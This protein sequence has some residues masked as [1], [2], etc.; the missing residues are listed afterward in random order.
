MRQDYNDFLHNLRSG[1]ALA[2]MRRVTVHDFRNTF[3]QLVWLVLFSLLLQLGSGFIIAFPNPD[4]SHYAF[5]TF[6]LGLVLFAFATYLLSLVLRRRDATLPLLVMF[7]SPSLVLYMVLTALAVLQRLLPVSQ[8]L[9]LG[10][11]GVTALLWVI[12]IGL[13][14]VV[15]TYQSPWRSIPLALVIYSLV[16]FV[17]LYSGDWGAEFWYPQEEIE[18]TTRD[19][20]RELDAESLLYAQPG[21]V[22]EALQQLTPQRA[23]VTDLYFVSFGGYAYQDVFMKE[24][25]YAHQT[26]DERFDTRGHSL[27]LVNNLKTREQLPLA[28][29]TNL[30]EVLNHLGQA[31][32]RE[33]D[34]LML[35]LTS[36]GSEKHELAIDFWPLPLN[37]LTPIKLRQMLDDAGIKWRVI[38]VSACYSGGF[39]EA[40][41]DEYTLVATAAAADRQSFGCSSENDFTYF[42]EA[43]FRDE[44]QREGTMLDAFSRTRESIA[45]RE[46]REKLEP[47]RPQLYI[48]PLIEQK[49]GEMRAQPRLAGCGVEEPDVAP[50]GC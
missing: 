48:A 6:G 37:D 29:S 12:V 33:Q 45:A 43:L 39:I 15:F 13:R 11:I 46:L 21:M 7:Y 8:L 4:F 25:R 19:P 16:C 36:H 2:M 17:P 3:D 38:V 23:D 34:V 32:D 1:L 26:M 5:S 28:S 27:E 22:A 30:R 24:V 35:Y 44:L 14:A 41:K 40:L 10:I 9:I 20:Y 42:G 18:T 47:S 50:V 49:L 31:M